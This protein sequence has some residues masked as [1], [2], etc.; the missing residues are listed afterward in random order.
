MQRFITLG[1][2]TF[3]LDCGGFPRLITLELLVS[4]VLP[5]LNA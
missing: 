1:V 3:M 5:A 2:D 4:D